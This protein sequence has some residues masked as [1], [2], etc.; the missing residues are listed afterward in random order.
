MVFNAT[1]FKAGGG[2]ECL[3][4]SFSF[5]STTVSMLSHNET[6]FSSSTKKG[7]RKLHKIP[8]TEQCF[9]FWR[10]GEKISRVSGVCFKQ[11]HSDDVDLAFVLASSKHDISSAVFGFCG[12]IIA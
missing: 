4:Y 11:E 9:L 1:I 2:G 5:P 7:T 3:E 10:E 12:F 8:K 6:I